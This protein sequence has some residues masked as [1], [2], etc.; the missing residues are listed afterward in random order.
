MNIPFAHVSRLAGDPHPGSFHR[1]GNRHIC[2]ACV[3]SCKDQ[4]DAATM[5]LLQRFG[6]VDLECPQENCIAPENAHRFVRG[7]NTEMVELASPSTLF[8]NT[9]L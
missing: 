1:R 5:P 8:K 7:F 3:D 6:Q 9:C 2:Q 4:L